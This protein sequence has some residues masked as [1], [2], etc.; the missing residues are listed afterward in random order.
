MGH[1]FCCGFS[2]FTMVSMATTVQEVFCFQCFHGLRLEIGSVQAHSENKMKI[3]DTG[4]T[5]LDEGGI[6]DDNFLRK[7]F[8]RW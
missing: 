4:V 1:V 5:H 2:F 3:C 8:E 7:N 6:F